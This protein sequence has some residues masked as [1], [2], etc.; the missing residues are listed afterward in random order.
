MV[1]FGVLAASHAAP[2][3]AQ[4]AIEAALQSDYR[5]RG[6]SLT[7][8]TPAASVSVSYDD[9]TGLYVAGLAVVTV[10]DAAGAPE[11]LGIQGAAGYAMRI[12]PT[13]SIDAGLSKTQYFSAYGSDRDYDYTEFHLGLSLPN[14]TA[15]LSYSPDYFRN[16]WETLYAELA[17][18]IEPGPDWTLSAHMG[19]LTYLHAP[20]AV[21]PKHTY[22]WQV[23]VSRQVGPWGLHV[24]LTGRILGPARIT[25]PSG[26]GSGEDH[27]AL[28]VGISRAF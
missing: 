16:D 15:R 23:G 24:D 25:L 14:V 12:S 2:A 28:M 5:V 6:Y 26:V 18:G 20:P 21:L 22:D 17:G 13:L 27:Q 19:V 10:D 7:D 3:C 9:P 8:E 1:A 11:L 4:V